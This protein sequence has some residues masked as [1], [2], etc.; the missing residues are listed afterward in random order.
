MKYILVILILSSCVN[1]EKLAMK[2]LINKGYTNIKTHAYNDC[3]CSNGDIYYS[4]FCGLLNNKTDSGYIYKNN[5]KEFKI[6]I[7]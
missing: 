3:I 2:Q 7:D 5:K 1:N 4:G 6:V